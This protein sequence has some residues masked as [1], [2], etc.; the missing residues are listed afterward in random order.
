MVGTSA[1]VSLAERKRAITRRRAG[2][3]RA[4]EIVDGIGGSLGEV[5]S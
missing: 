2:M 1:T 5:I 4:T 3:V